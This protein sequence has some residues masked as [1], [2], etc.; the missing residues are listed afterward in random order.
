MTPSDT[1]EGDVAPGVAVAV[2]L[3]VT[4][5]AVAGTAGVLW[6]LTPDDEP[7]APTAVFDAE[8]DATAVAVDGERIEVSRVTFRHEGGDRVPADEL[9]VRVRD[10]SPRPR[11]L[12]AEGRVAT[13]DA[14]VV[15]RGDQVSVVAAARPEEGRGVEF[16]VEAVDG[17]RRLTDGNGTVVELDPGDEVALVWVDGGR[18]STLRVLEVADRDTDGG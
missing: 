8:Q 12:D 15:Q 4:V 11:G 14:D 13:F 5:V 6:T 10:G 17:E 9:E 7:R 16:A 1:G 3:G 18:S 2:L